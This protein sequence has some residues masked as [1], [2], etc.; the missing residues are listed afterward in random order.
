MG[1]TNLDYK[2]GHRE[3]TFYKY[4]LASNDHTDRNDTALLDAYQPEEIY[5]HYIIRIKEKFTL[6]NHPSEV[7]RIPD[8]YECIDVA[9]AD[10][11]S[12]IPD[13]MPYLNSFA[14]A[15]S[16]NAEKC[17]WHIIYPRARFIDY[18]E[19]KGFT[20]KVMELVG[21]PYSKFIDN[22]LPK[23]H[24]NLQ[25]LGSAKEGRIKRPAIFLVKNGFKNLDDYLVQPKENYSV[26]W[27]RTFSSEESVKAEFQPIDDDDALVKGA[28]LAFAE[29]GWLQIGRIEKGFINFQ[30]QSVKE[31]SIYDVKH[32]NDQLYGFIHQ[33]GY[34]VLKCYRQKQYKPEH[35]GLSFGKVSDKV[36]SKEKPKKWGLC[37]RLPKAVKNPCPLVDLSGNNI[38]VKE[39]KNTPEA[40]PDF[41]S[42]EP[43]TTLIRL[44]VA[45]GK[46]KTLREILNSLAKSEANLPCFNWVS[47]RKTLSNE[48]KSKIEVL[49]KSGLRVE[50][51]HR[52]NFHEGHF[53]VVILDE[54]NGIMHQ[55]ASGIH[56]QES[57]NAMRDLL[58]S[59]VH[60]VAMDAFANELTLAFLRQYRGENIQV[61]NNKYQPRKSETV[62]ILYD[63]NKGS[64]AIR[65]GLEM[66]KEG[67]RVVFSMTSCKKARAIANQ[68]SKLQKPDGSFILSCVYF[69]QMDGKQ[70]QD[71]FADINATWSG[72]D[73]V[74]YTSTVES[75]ILFEIPNYFD[76]VIAISNIKT[77]VHAEA[78]TQ[79]LY[80]TRDCPYHI[81]SLYNSKTHSEIFKE[82]NRDLI[83]AELS[84][85][86][87]GD[88]P[89]AIK[90]CCEWNKITDCY[91]LDS[92]LTVETYIEIE[93]QRCLSAK[94]FPKILCSLIASTELSLELIAVEDTKLAKASRTE[95]SHTIKNTE[96]LI[97]GKDAELIVNASD[98]NPN[99]AEMLKLNPECS[100]ANN[101]TLQRYYLWRTYASGN[102]GSSN[103][104]K[105]I[106][107][108]EVKE[109]MQWEDSHESVDPSSEKIVKIR[110]D[111]LLLFGFKTRTKGMPN[112][113]ATIKFINAILGNWCGYTVKGGRKK[114]RPKGQQVWK[115]TYWI[116]CVS[117]NEVD[118]MTQERIIAIKLNDPNYRLT[119]PVLS[120]YK[121][122]SVDEIQ[123]FFDSILMCLD[124]SSAIT[125]DIVVSEDAKFQ[126]SISSS[127]EICEESSCTNIVEKSITNL[128]QLPSIVSTQNQSNNSEQFSNIVEAKKKLPE[129][130]ISL[131]SEYLIKNESD[132]NNLTLFLQQKFQMS[133]EKLEQWQIKIA[134]EMR[135]NQDYWKKEHES[136]DEVAF[137]EYK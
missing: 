18:R 13:Y 101:M 20:E 28:N 45:S 76:A 23:T 72:L 87:P 115:S 98:I 2:P 69:S 49:Q 21:E 7:Y 136:M 32:N 126:C 12:L 71:D 90:E 68:A 65:K 48:T 66:L 24:F 8:I 62:K 131:S 34:F 53:H 107:N 3:Y 64:E 125:T 52:L 57:E 73:C 55:M 40:Y 75:G 46:T 33:N 132:I 10:A 100:F 31:C 122:E 95:V 78:F 30:A 96:K 92:S 134:F 9:C 60:V 130:L 86:R 17:S 44:P 41:M 15:S 37:E 117:D 26:I 94:Y 114:V 1:L 39:M 6:V 27:P 108:L 77:G 137:L 50:S 14:L 16:S 81:V 83:R 70:R 133:K 51:T 99:E 22:G 82:P 58:K 113:N 121:S 109:E 91:I 11:L 42:E 111:A 116:H 118:F 59:A 29:Y 38:N 85:L 127:N 93:Y 128:P 79:M 54:A 97:K 103:A 43:T 35:K 36:K 112:L 56:A 110:E 129:S 80:R 67:K 63:S 123:E 102:I 88:L 5:S 25:L 89:T 119:D 47:Y 106:E 4:W 61:F 84:A 105:A 124:I 74:I 135:N 104:T 120:P 19:L